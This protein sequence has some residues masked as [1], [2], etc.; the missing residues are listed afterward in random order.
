MEGAPELQRSSLPLN[1]NLEPQGQIHPKPLF[2]PCYFTTPVSGSLLTYEAL[3]HL[4]VSTWEMPKSLWLFPLIPHDIVRS[5]PLHLIQ[6]PLVTKWIHF[7]C[8]GFVDAQDRFFPVWPV[9][10]LAMSLPNSNS[11][12]FLLHI[13]TNNCG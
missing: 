11:C 13:G 12:S 1:S 10:L 5:V 8:P 6:V 3:L 9:Y 7:S 2:G 4:G